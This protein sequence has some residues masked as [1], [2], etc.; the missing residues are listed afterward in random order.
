MNFIKALASAGILALMA[1][2]ALAAGDHPMGFFVT[3][4]GMGNGADL[5]GLEGADAHCT[6]LAEAAGSKGRTWGAYLST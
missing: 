4:I 6:T 2:P 1:A 5:G 3:S